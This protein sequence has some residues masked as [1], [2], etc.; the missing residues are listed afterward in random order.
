[1]LHQL[2]TAVATSTYSSNIPDSM[3]ESETRSSTSARVGNGYLIVT[4]VVS[5]KGVFSMYSVLENAWLD[6]INTECS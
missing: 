4:G 6:L 5:V 2:P 1:M 3:K